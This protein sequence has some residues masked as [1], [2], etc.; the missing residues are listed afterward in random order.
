MIAT[1]IGK[2]GLQFVEDELNAV[3]F[4]KERSTL[5][6]Q[7]NPSPFIRSI[8]RKFEDYFLKG[9]PLKDIPYRLQGTPF[10]NKVWEALN[11]IPFAQTVTYGDLAK[12]LRTGPRAI[13]A[14][15]RT[16]LLPILIPCH[17]V[18]A[19]NSLGGFAGKSE[20]ML[21]IKKWLLTHEG[22]QK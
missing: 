4:I 19:Q 16:N 15:C 9:N 3:H 14:A 1:P 22:Q 18:V 12:D 11:E 17:R 10:Q 20:S 5:I 2:L 6:P 21:K 13:G 8:I 7:P